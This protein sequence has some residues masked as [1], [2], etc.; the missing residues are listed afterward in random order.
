MVANKSKRIGEVVNGLLAIGSYKGFSK[1][2]KSKQSYLILKCQKC[3]AEKNVLRSVF[4]K[5]NCAC[6]CS[7]KREYTGKSE[8]RI[9][10][11]YRSILYRTQCKT[12]KDYK[13]Y[14]ARGITVCDEWKKSFSSFYNWAVSNGYKEGLTIDRIDNNGDYSPEN[15]RWI[16][17]EEQQ[18]NK[19]IGV[20]PYRN[21]KGQ[22]SSKNE[23]GV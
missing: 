5:G 8:T 20:N 22:Y 1:T 17:I 15:C 14:G 23:V 19:R 13:Y 2:G 21:K 18:K 6:S 11:V 10:R 7:Y 12:C 9:Y 16:T 3:G 4:V